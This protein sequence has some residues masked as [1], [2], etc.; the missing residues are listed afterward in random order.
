MTKKEFDRLTKKNFDLRSTVTGRR[1]RPSSAE[2]NRYETTREKSRNQF[3]DPIF[4]RRPGGLSEAMR[5]VKKNEAFDK[6]SRQAP[7]GNRTER[8]QKV[9]GR[10]FR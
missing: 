8:L 2:V 4:G 9:F 5:T 6:R 3:I 10:A 7:V 1:L